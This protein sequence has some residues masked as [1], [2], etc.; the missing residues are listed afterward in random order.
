MDVSRIGGY[1]F[2]L[3]N[4]VMNVNSTNPHKPSDNPNNLPEFKNDSVIVTISDEARKAVL[5]IREY[6]SA[7]SFL[8]FD[9]S[10]FSQE[11]KDKLNADMAERINERNKE[12]A[13]VGVWYEF[14]E[15]T[16]E[17]FITDSLVG[18]ARNASLVAGELSQMIRS[19]AYNNGATVEE[20]AVMRET[21]MKNAEYIAHNYFD[22]P[23]EAK[24]FLDGIKRFYEYDILREKGYT[25]IDNAGIAPF[26]SY[27]SLPDGNIS[28]NTY[29]KKFGASDI[30][31]IYNNP[32]T[33]KEFN[34]A[35]NVNRDKWNEEIIKDFEDNE[36]KV[37]DIINLVKNSLNENIVADSL[38]HLLRAF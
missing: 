15:G 13:I 8:K 37:I 14:D 25:V 33:K 18:K 32:Q 6:D 22:N 31:E 4:K 19:A 24:A 1:N 35:L 34:N 17:K 38:T 21:G 16:L 9:E 10:L 36:R 23:N 7:T 3:Q 5:Q 27:I 28:L 2:Y 26:K 11:A 30:W 29:A 20:R 12:F